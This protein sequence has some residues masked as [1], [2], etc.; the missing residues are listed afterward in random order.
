MGTLGA[1]GGAG[2]HWERLRTRHWVDWGT[3]GDTGGTGDTRALGG[4]GG[5][6]GDTRSTGDSRGTGST[7]GHWE[8]SGR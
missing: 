7:V 3:L 5:T 8:Q 1:R 6:L 4:L 2:G